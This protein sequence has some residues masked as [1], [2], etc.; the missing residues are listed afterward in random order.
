[1]T[2][3]RSCRSPRFDF[4]LLHRPR[5]DDHGQRGQDQADD[6]DDDIRG[7]QASAQTGEHHSVTNL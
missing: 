5:D 7:Q 6:N 4:P 1:M 2:G 3:L